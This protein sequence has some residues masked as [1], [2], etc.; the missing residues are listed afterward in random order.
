MFPPPIT[1]AS[2]TSSSLRAL[3]TSVAMRSTAAPSMVSSDAALARA[4]PD[5]LSTTRRQ[6]GLSS[7][8]C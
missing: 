6:A 2:S 1:T 3:A 8:P 5:S 4:S 7:P